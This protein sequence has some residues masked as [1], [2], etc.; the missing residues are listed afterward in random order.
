MDKIKLNGDTSGYIEI[1]APAVSGNNT[2]ELGPGT[3]ILTNLDNTFTGVSTFTSGLQVTG[4]NVAVGHN[5]PSVNLHVKG[6]ASN[7]QIYLGGTG[8]HSQ[9]YAD[10]DGVLILNADQGNSAANSYLGFNVDNS[11]RVRI[12]SSGNMQVSSGQF[13]V[14][15]TAST[16]LQLINDGTFGTIQ[17]ADLKIRTAATERLRISSDGPHLLLGGTADVNEIT[18][19]TAHDIANKIFDLGFDNFDLE[20]TEAVLTE[21]TLRKGDRGED[22]KVLQ[23]QLLDLGFDPNGVDGIF[24]PGT[25]RA[26]RAFQQRAGITVD[27][28]AGGQT[29]AAISAEAAPRNAGKERRGGEWQN[30]EGTP[31]SPKKVSR[32]R[33]G[34]LRDY[35][36]DYTPENWRK[37]RRTHEAVTISDYGNRNNP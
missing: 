25:E 35:V 19:N 37:L 29:Q 17:S 4:G 32:L 16:G 22:V 1:S 30:V 12:D 10:N 34:R 9:I 36:F 8:A 11:E 26:L 28:L 24:G 27:G 18:E 31:G 5:N 13:T 6:S 2:L 3:K 7:G 15:T 21:R 33:V 14:G 20:I 23:Q